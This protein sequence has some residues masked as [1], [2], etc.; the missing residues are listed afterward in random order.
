[1]LQ[2]TMSGEYA[3]RA[4]VQLSTLPHGTVVSV[5][6]L[7]RDGD[8]PVTFLKK[9]VTKLARAGMVT[10]FRGNG[11]GIALARPADELTT[12]DVI[13]AVEGQLSLNICVL[14][15]DTCHRTP[16][17]A[18]YELW[19]EAQNKLREVLSSKSLADL[20][21]IPRAATKKTTSVHK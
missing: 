6:E 15:P 21:G 1:M 17:C 14:S 20:A 8:V 11:G 13:E 12:L 16:S 9:I 19:C 18:V 5:A 4:M 10:S 2:L 7:S 3:V